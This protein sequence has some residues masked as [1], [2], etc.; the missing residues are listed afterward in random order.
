MQRTAFGQRHG[1]RV[2]DQRHQH[3]HAIVQVDIGI[4]FVVQRL[5][6]YLGL[7]LRGFHARLPVTPCGEVDVLHRLVQ[8]VAETA[9][10]EARIDRRAVFGGSG[11]FGQ[12][13]F[14]RQFRAGW[15]ISRRCWQFG[16]RRFD[17][18]ASA[19]IGM[20]QLGEAVDPPVV[21]HAPGQCTYR[22]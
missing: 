8:H 4:A 6:Q 2:T 13:R 16:G 22:R 15:F 5:A 11:G 12:R 19:S 10:H 21:R 9:A 7:P 14:Q 1:E 20:G 3:G 17:V 18:V